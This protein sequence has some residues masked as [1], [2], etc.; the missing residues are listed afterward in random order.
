F[1]MESQKNEE[2]WSIKEELELV[3]RIQEILPEK[4]KK[5]SYLKT[6][7][8]LDWSTISTQTKSPELC[9]KQFYKLKLMI[10]ENISLNQILSEIMLIL[11]DPKLRKSN[12]PNPH[13]A[14]LN[15]NE[16]KVRDSNGNL[17][18]TSSAAAIRCKELPNNIQHLY[19]SQYEEQLKLKNLIITKSKSS[20][21]H[22]LQVSKED[23]RKAW[24]SW[25]LLPFEDKIP[26]I[27][28]S[29]MDETRY[30]ED[31]AEYLFNNPNAKTLSVQ[32]PT[33]D[34]KEK[35]LIYK[36]MPKSPPKK[37]SL[38]FLESCNDI[39]TTK[40]GKNKLMV[41]Q[42]VF[43]DL[44]T[45]LQQNTKIEF[46]EAWDKYYFEFNEWKEQQTPLI[47]NL[48]ELYNKYKRNKPN[49]TKKKSMDTE[50]KVGLRNPNFSSYSANDN[51]QSYMSYN[52]QNKEN[53]CQIFETPNI[54]TIQRVK[55]T[56]TAQKKS[57]V[58][59]KESPSFG[60]RITLSFPSNISS[61]SSNIKNTKNLK[62]S[63]TLKRKSKDNQSVSK[64][65][66]VECLSKNSNKLTDTKGNQHES[67]VF[68]EMIG[69]PK[70]VAKTPW[71]YCLSEQMTIL[72]SP[73]KARRR[74]LKLFKKNESAI[75]TIH[76]LKVKDYKESIENFYH[77]LPNEHKKV[78]LESRIYLIDNTKYINIFQDLLVSQ[79]DNI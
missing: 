50:S 45:D 35:Y 41:A 21:S 26:Y 2:F 14:F 39:E 13:K 70:P 36:G 20:F 8:N 25:C 6:L 77:K 64:K 32:G 42:R 48:S 75:K 19:E 78:Y 54:S 31:L 79:F 29:I 22:F 49:N 57:A 69:E 10:L 66:K 44:P 24:K 74:A 30:K 37:C 76:H 47:Q 56:S 28:M 7:S 63:I 33:W 67:A 5:L 18:M 55:N 1:T 61:I 46:H 43:Q 23:R 34:E 38:L 60:R 40:L 53:L 9:R 17:K 72:G 71:L 15:E 65:T 68:S 59:Y 58:N 16:K 62:S 73:G 4:A 3:K 51:E 27:E 12:S 52:L 11:Q